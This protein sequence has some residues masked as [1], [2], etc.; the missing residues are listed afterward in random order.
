MIDMTTFVAEMTILKDRFGRRDMTAETIARYHDFLNPRLNTIEFQGA[1][2]V[3]FNKDRFWPPP[4]RFIDAAQGG[5]DT[6]LAE[7][8]WQTILTLARQGT[9]PVPHEL[10]NEVRAA[11][12]A[13]P[14]REIMNADDFALGRLRKDFIAAFV[15]TKL[16]LVHQDRHALDGIETDAPRLTG[17]EE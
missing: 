3:I 15:T 16:D 2:R 10:P 6:D 9:Y 7:E 4:Q 13:A 5:S 12:K 17:G 11:L 14:M 8:S 1:A